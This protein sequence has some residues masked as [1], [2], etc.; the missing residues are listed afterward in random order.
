ML[1]SG[2]QPFTLLDYPDKTACIVFTPGCN[3]RCG[4]CHNSEFVLPEKIKELKDAWIPEDAFFNFLETRKNLLDGVVI[5]GGEPT[6]MGDI[7]PFAKKIKERGFLVKVDTNGAASW[8][9]EKLLQE[10]VVDYIA[11]DIKT[12][13]ENYPAVSGSCVLPT[14]IKKSVELIM[15]SGIAY[16]FRSTLLQELHDEKT[17]HEM[18]QLIR[19]ARAWYLQPFRSAKT[20]DVAFQNH[21]AL[22]KEAMEDIV[23]KYRD[24]IDN[25]VIRNI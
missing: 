10:H 16:E 7:I 5:S 25:I 8:V 2:I 22:H 1:L 18:A 3:F 12:S 19:G 4:Y 6:L 14:A 17:V 9:L 23:M 13:L 21:H 15:G 24:I 11:M 20:L